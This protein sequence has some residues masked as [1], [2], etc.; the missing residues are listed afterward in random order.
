[1]WKFI[2]ISIT[3][4]NNIDVRVM[5]YFATKNE[6]ERNELFRI[7]LANCEIR[8][9]VRFFLCIHSMF[10]FVWFNKMFSFKQSLIDE[11]ENLAKR[12]TPNVFLFS[13]FYFH[14]FS[15]WYSNFTVTLVWCLG[16]G[17]NFLKLKGLLK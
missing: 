13:S 15:A 8:T 5:M 2:V 9:K 10:C 3:P 7:V 6:Y 14:I 4:H 12:T 17:R 1:M 16:K 11:K